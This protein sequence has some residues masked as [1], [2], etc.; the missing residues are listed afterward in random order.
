MLAIECLGRI[1]K[2]KL[3]GTALVIWDLGRVSFEKK[4]TDTKLAIWYLGKDFAPKT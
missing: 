3:W 1:F 4:Q 2:K